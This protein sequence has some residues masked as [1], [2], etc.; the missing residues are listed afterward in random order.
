MH[1]LKPCIEDEANVIVPVGWRAEYTLGRKL[2]QEWDT[3]PIFGIPTQRDAQVV[4]LIGYSVHAG[5]DDYLAHVRAITPH[6]Q[7][8]F[9]VH[10][11]ER[12]T[13][14][15]AMKLTTAFPNMEM[16]VPRTDSRYDM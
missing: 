1:H 13:L 3:I 11:E 7:K 8:V 5:R 10:G 4:R 15:F 14:S 12:H 16:E 2:A 9:V 6:P